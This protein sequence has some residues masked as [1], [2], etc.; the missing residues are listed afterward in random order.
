MKGRYYSD[1]K[2][3]YYQRCKI[4]HKSSGQRC[5]ICTGK[6][7]EVHHSSY[8][9]DIVGK[10]I[11]PVCSSCHMNICHAPNNWIKS[12]NKMKSKNTNEFILYLRMQFDFINIVHNPINGELSYRTPPH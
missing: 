2:S 8:G 12:N 5:T 7:T 6:S 3:T 4:A 1:K 9:N 11:F 10:S